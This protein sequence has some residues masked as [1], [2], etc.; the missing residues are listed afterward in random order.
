M[1]DLTETERGA[2]DAD[3]ASAIGKVLAHD[4]ALP[5]SIM[6]RAG[7]RQE[8][9]SLL[10]V[11]CEHILAVARLAVQSK[12]RVAALD[13]RLAAAEARIAALE[14]ERAAAHRRIILP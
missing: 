7:D 9:K 2:L 3:Y 8:P 1:P 14:T 6:A 4:R 13:T 10:A 12:Q 5:A 11:A